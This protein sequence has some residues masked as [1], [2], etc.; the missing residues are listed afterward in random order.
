MMNWFK[1]RRP[2]VPAAASVAGAGRAARSPDAAPAPH[3]GVAAEATAPPTGAVLAAS[4]ARM[5]GQLG[6]RARAILATL[7]RGPHADDV[8]H[9][10]DLVVNSEEATI[11]PIPTAAKRAMSLARNPESSLAEVADAFER[12]PSLAEGLLRLA[13]SAWYRGRDEQV[14]SLHDALQRTGSSGAEIVIMGNSLKGTLCRPGGAYDAMVTQVWLHLSRTAPIA[15]ALAGTFRLEPEAA[16]MLGLLHD[17]GKLVLFDAMS[18][19]RR[20]TRQAAHMPYPLLREIVMQLHEPLGGLAMLRWGLDP[21][22]AG[23]VADHHR[24]GQPHLVDPVS[25]L[26]FV[27][28]RADLVLA[29]ARP[30]DP[31]EWIS[32][33]GL[34]IGRLTLR[35]ALAEATG[36]S[37]RLVEADEGGGSARAA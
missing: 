35:R 4:H 23:A 33:G 9:L 30:C 27:A 19:F 29:G 16:F 5:Q 20:R 2:A 22:R 6:E 31:S 12:D 1:G 21:D 32:E 36:G 10:L 7:G 3:G 14:D 25:E 18:E 24:R 17:A 11:R 28:E 37:L 8:R 26:L 13:N 34:T 15:R